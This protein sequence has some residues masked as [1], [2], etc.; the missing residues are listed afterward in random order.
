MPLKKGFIHVYT[1]NGKGKTSAALGLCLR[2]AG[3]G[4]QCCFIQFVKGRKT[5][6]MET[7]KKIENIEF[8]QT[9]RPDYNFTVTDED[10]D[11]A[12]RGLKIASEKI[13]E[14]DVVVLDEINVAVHLGLLNKQ[15][16]LSLIKNKPK[17]VELILTGRFAKR[18]IIEI[19]DYVTEFQ[20]IKHP[21]YRGEDA[22]E[23]IDY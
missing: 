19:A 13:K 14:F 21:F 7:I 16:V 20:L 11:R 2:A 9:G 3:R 1:G 8:I 5:G 12:R 17:N 18:E 23:G 6:E 10:Y 15:D 4:L 22:R